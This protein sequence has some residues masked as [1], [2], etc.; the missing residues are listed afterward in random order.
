MMALSLLSD[1]LADLES[2]G[3]AESF[4]QLLE[5]CVAS[6]F[7]LTDTVR[8]EQGKMCHLPARG[9]GHTLPWLLIRC[10]I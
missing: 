9:K 4:L 1:L 8:Q 2:A 5:V 10:S 3:L 7:S 6:A